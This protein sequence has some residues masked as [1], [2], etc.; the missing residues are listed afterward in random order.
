MLCV[1]AVGDGARG[2]AV[3]AFRRE[4]RRQAPLR[5]RR[6]ALQAVPRVVRL[7]R[8]TGGG[9][10]RVLGGDRPRGGRGMRGVS[11]AASRGLSHRQTEERTMAVA[12]RRRRRRPPGR[13]RPRPPRLA[14]RSRPVTGLDHPRLQRGRL[15]AARDDGRRRR[16]AGLGALPG[17]RVCRL[18]DLDAALDVRHENRRR[19]V[20]ARG[21]RRPRLRLRLL[22]LREPAHAPRRRRQTSRRRRRQVALRRGRR[23]S[24][25]PRFRASGRLPALRLVV[26][27][28]RRSSGASPAH[29]E[30]TRVGTPAPAPRQTPRR[31]LLRSVV[32]EGAHQALAR[33]LPARGRGPVAPPKNNFLQES[34]PRQHLFF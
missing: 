20:D 21:Q 27:E 26:P 14:R 12:L 15:V 11:G 2:G 7:R 17:G 32:R 22:D 8:K 30:S 4:R 28:S 3:G 13:R 25:H 5:R 9:R 31:P 24:K 1:A 16:R 19:H 23:R 18:A 10:P 6:I 34:R 29:S 33:P